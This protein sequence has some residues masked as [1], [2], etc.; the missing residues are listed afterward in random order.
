MDSKTVKVL[1]R[2]IDKLNEE[3]KAFGKE[4]GEDWPT[5]YE[6]P[7]TSFRI[8]NIRLNET[9]HLLK[10]GY[11]FMDGRG[12]LSM[13]EKTFGQPD[14]VRE[15]LNFWGACLR[16]AKK[17]WSMDSESLDRLQDPDNDTQEDDEE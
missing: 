8:C 1:Q 10:Y 12:F 16:R 11:D 13:T 15:Y 17:Y 5:L 9:G 3:L 6:D 14:E 2:R 7:Y 4:S